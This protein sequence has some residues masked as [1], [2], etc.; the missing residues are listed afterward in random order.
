MSKM[1]W[2]LGIALVAGLVWGCSSEDSGGGGGAGNN[3]AAGTTSGGS[4]GST[5]GSG[6]TAGEATGGSGGDAAGTGGGAG[7]SGDGF[8]PN[9]E[10]TCPSRSIKQTD[11]L[12]YCRPATLSVCP[13]ACA[14]LMVDANHCG[15]CMTACGMDQVCN[16]GMC[17][18]SPTVTV[19]AAAGCGA[20]DLAISGT[21]LLWTDTMHGT[22]NA[23]PSGAAMPTVLAATATMPTLIEASA[24]AA[25][26]LEGGLTIMT[27]PIAG[28]AATEVYTSATTINGL[29]VSEDGMTVYFS[30]ETMVNSVPAA[31]GT[32]TLVGEEESGIP[33][34][35]V[36]AGDLVGTLADLNGDVDVMTVV[37]GTPAYCA[38]ADD[39]ELAALI[40]NCVRLGRS[41]G[42]LN[43][44]R[45]AII[46]DAAYW[47]NQA[48]I[49]TASATNPTGV[50]D[51]VAQGSADAFTV[52]AWAQDGTNAYFADNAGNVYKTP[53]MVNSEAVALSR[54]QADVMSMVTDGTNVY[55]AAADC[56][57]LSVA[58]N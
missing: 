4:G 46:G 40:T 37:D 30:T 57:I 18:A 58:A 21:T 35:L 42:S 33:K 26:W 31:G 52:N 38:S 28:G 19:A 6:G 14:D 53:L 5:A 9:A 39:P 55:W 1:R 11:G 20:I 43:L 34:G 56:S 51:T 12:C 50:N 41:Q 49:L 10:G 17:G 44:R 25:F 7:A 32:V 15:D 8:P 45:M 2:G 29:A 47:A 13:D 27:A 23:L 54:N 22:V 36:V 24:T 3:S 48:T 16:A